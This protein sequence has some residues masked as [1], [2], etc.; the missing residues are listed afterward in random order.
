[1][2]PALSTN[3]PQNQMNF[4]IVLCHSTSGFHV[5]RHILAGRP[6]DLGSRFGRLIADTWSCR[7]KS[8]KTQV[9]HR[10]NDRALN[11]AQARDQRPRRQWRMHNLRGGDTALSPDHR[12]RRARPGRVAVRGPVAP[13]R[14]CLHQVAR[15]ARFLNGASGGFVRGSGW[16]GR[17]PCTFDSSG[18]RRGA[19]TP[20]G[21]LRSARGDAGHRNRRMPASA[22]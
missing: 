21:T 12:G 8:V 20:S 5:D 7:G 9:G 6:L 1:M 3:E 22:I 10:S 18:R 19:E 2:G 14:R 11:L 16:S 17:S 15:L 4:R 13:R